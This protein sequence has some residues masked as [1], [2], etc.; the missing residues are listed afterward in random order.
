MEPMPYAN[1]LVESAERIA[2]VTVNRPEKRNALDRATLD[3]LAACFADLAADSSVGAVVVAG[4][5]GKAFVAGADLNHIRGMSPLQAREWSYVG[6]AVYARIEAMDKPVIAAIDGWAMGGGLELAMA[7]HIRVASTASRMGQPEVKLGIVP[8]WGGTQRLA[9][10]V[11]RGRALEMLLTG[12]P[13]DAE[14]ALRI[15]LVEHLTAPGEAAAKA[16]EIAA[17][18]LKNGPV[19]AALILQAVRQGLDMPLG[20]ALEWESAQFTVSSATED[21]REGVA[22]FLEK[23]E[24][25]FPGR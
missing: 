10:L 9:R 17:K 2:T 22:A 25:R 5:G 14:Q 12:D 13:I 18:I 8:G 20:A 11:G 21:I 3:A 4:A 1:L 19:A 15:G 24:P 7:C 6:Q 23:R 16:Q